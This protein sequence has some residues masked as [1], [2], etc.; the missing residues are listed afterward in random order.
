M[1]SILPEDYKRPAI[2]TYL[3]PDAIMAY[4]DGKPVYYDPKSRQYLG[5]GYYILS[6]ACDKMKALEVSVLLY[7]IGFG[8]ILF[9]LLRKSAKFRQ[10]SLHV[11]ILGIPIVYE[12]VLV[13]LCIIADYL[14]CG[15]G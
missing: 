13:S 2:A 10:I 12:V 15:I 11:F 9:I 4:S 1:D 7:S 3:F 8:I 5:E 14:V 6:M